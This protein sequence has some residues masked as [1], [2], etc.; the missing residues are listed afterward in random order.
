MILLPIT[1]DFVRRTCG[2]CGNYQALDQWH[3]RCQAHAGDTE[4]DD[5]GCER[6]ES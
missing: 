5:T 3:G 6:Y 1:T 2:N 4:P